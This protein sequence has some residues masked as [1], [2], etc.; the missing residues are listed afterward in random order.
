MLPL[1]VETGRYHGAKLEEKCGF[2]NCDMLKVCS[3]L[4]AP[5]YASRAGSTVICH[6]VITLPFPH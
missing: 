4:H 2:Y 5:V 1:K 6:I 3:D